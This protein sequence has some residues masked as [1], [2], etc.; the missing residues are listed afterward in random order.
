[1]DIAV[2]T[3]ILQR[4]YDHVILWYETKMELSSLNLGCLSR[5]PSSCASMLS[6]CILFS[7]CRVIYYSIGSPFFCI[8]LYLS[9][10]IYIIRIFVYVIFYLLTL[11]KP[12]ICY[13]ICTCKCLC[14]LS[15]CLPVSLSPCL[16]VSLSLDLIPP[17]Y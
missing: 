2:G 15:A 9:L 13:R 6:V 10:S 3:V 17:L 16:P 14:L 7:S 5:F 8:S 4:E 1:M 11:L 12:Y